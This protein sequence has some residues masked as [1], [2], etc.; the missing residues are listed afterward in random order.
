MGDTFD[1]ANEDIV[2]GIEGLPEMDDQEVIDEY[3]NVGIY[4][5][6]VTDIQDNLGN[7]EF[8]NAYINSIPDINNQSFKLR[9][10]FCQKMLDAIFESY[11]FQFP[12]SIDIVSDAGIARVLEFIKFIEY[13]NILFL[14]L[15]WEMLKT[16]IL[17]TNIRT[18]SEK[19]G[20]I[21][22]KEVEEQLQTHH[23]GELI[24]IFLRTYYKEKFIQW[25][26]RE[27][28]NSKVFIK[29]EILEREGKLNGWNHN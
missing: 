6:A 8:K 24:S 9:R 3:E 16:D 27:S 2:L 14:S 26:I 18:F 5:A 12:E 11:D 25:F 13:D 29:L 17:K 1:A 20:N 22:I 10:I 4:N 23:Q 7:P 15:V 21:I 28:E 19:N